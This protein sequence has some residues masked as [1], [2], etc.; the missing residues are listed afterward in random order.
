MTQS[1]I[2][3]TQ[4]NDFVGT[5]AADRADSLDFANYLK[6]KGLIN[7]DEFLVGFE[8]VF[9]ENSG[10]SVP[11]PGIVAFVGSGHSVDDVAAKKA[12]DGLFKLRNVEVFDLPLAD[13]FAYFKRFNIMLANAAL[14]LSGVE[15]DT[16]G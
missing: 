13:F 8:I 11:D 5:V 7:D 14:H 9:N 12:T 16:E 2:A 6:G 15:F 10:S 4:Y 1:F 3:A